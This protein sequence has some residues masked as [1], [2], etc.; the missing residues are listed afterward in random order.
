MLILLHYWIVEKTS[1]VPKS[2]YFFS[3]TVLYVENGT[4][5]SDVYK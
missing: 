2:L 3:M 4:S 1:L 5:T